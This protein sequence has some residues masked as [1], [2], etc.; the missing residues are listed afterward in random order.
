M[1]Y[2]IEVGSNG[3]SVKQFNKHRLEEHIKSQMDYGYPYRFIKAFDE[4]KQGKAL[5][6]NGDIVMPREKKV[7]IEYEVE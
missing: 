3:I 5:L 7:V 4:I 2:L 1:Y 6:I